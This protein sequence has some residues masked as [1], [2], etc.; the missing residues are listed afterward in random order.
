VLHRPVEACAGCPVGAN[1]EADRM[2]GSMSATYDGD[3]K[4]S[5]LC[6]LGMHKWKVRNVGGT[7]RFMACTRCNLV[8]DDAIRVFPPGL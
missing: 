5:P 6:L 3:R 4:W 1:V 2:G 8:D 7:T